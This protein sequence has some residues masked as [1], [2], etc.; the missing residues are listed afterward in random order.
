MRYSK[1]RIPCILKWVL[2]IHYSY[3]IREEGAR[4]PSF[5]EDCAS[6]GSKFYYMHTYTRRRTYQINAGDNY[7]FYLEFSEML[8]DD[9]RIAN[10]E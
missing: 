1:Y 8:R 10:S 9:T 6:S 7:L 3:I 4:Y 5:V 2:G